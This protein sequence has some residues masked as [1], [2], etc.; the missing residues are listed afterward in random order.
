MPKSRDL[1]I[2]VVT[3]RQVN[4]NPAGMMSMEGEYENPDKIL[5]PSGQWNETTAVASNYETTRIL[6]NSQQ[7][8][9]ASTDVSVCK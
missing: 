1:A 4:L 9:H 2:F 3:D 6:A 7:L 8:E 5:K